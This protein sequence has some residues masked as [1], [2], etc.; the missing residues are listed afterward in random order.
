MRKRVTSEFGEMEIS[1]PRDR[2]GEFAPQVVRKHQSNVTGIEDQRSIVKSR[3]R[4]S[5]N[6]MRIR[7]RYTVSSGKLQG[8]K[9]S[10]W[11]Q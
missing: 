10:V 4:Y 1:V 9:E 5:R 8:K 11:K 7:R 2:E 3:K 6:C